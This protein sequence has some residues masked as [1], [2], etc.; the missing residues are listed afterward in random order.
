MSKKKEITDYSVYKRLL[1]YVAPHKTSIIVAIVLASVVS[2]ATGAIAWIVK[3]VMDQLF[4]QK[5]WHMLNIL[6]FA[7][8]LIFLIKGLGRFYQ[9]YLMRRL[10]ETII[11]Q[12]R[13]ELYD[14]LLDMSLGY[15]QRIHSAVLMSRITNDVNLLADISSRVIAD[16]FRQVFTLVVLLGV[17]FY[18]N[19]R[20]ALIYCVVTPLVVVPITIIGK[21]LRRISKENQKKIAH[22]N[23][24]LMETFVGTKIVK[25]FTMEGYRKERFSGENHKLYK[26]N[27]RGIVAYELLSPMMESMG[28]VGMGLVIYFGGREVIMGHTSPG[29]FFS[30][31]AALGML[32]APLRKLSKMHGVVQKSLA[33][34]ERV[35]EVLDEKNEIVDRKEAIPLERLEDSIVFN[36]VTFSYDGESD[37]LK[38]IN[39]STRLGESIALVGLS[40]GGKST[41]VDLIARFYE[42]NQGTITL[43]QV[44]IRDYQVKSLRESIAIVTQEAVLF[45]DTIM[46]NIAYGRENPDRQEVIK[47]ARM[48][49]A[50]D[51]INALPDGYETMIQERGTNF[52]GGQRKRI[53]LARAFYKNADILI[54]DEASSELDSESEELVKQALEKLLE[55][56]TAFIV[57]HRLSTIMH[58]DQILV[59]EKG[60]ITERGT[61]QELLE[62]RGVYR[63][64]CSL[65]FID[66]ESDSLKKP[67]EPE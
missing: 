59:I 21:K 10:G 50:H 36:N 16:F 61:H 64:L 15:Y 29:T 2:V 56:K 67:A 53:T 3:P 34:A 45:N 11:T 27:M 46:N 43:D 25:A 63:K 6:P 51:F 42:V 22:L 9:S 39:L 40:G 8:V 20:L 33:A 28:A 41:L 17:V 31:L 57:A 24:I 54:L 49:Y 65:Q 35:F 44:D 37:V 7:L 32:Y 18:H 19:W 4:V 60:R 52:S 47:A 12:L 5:D 38:D 26:I 55:G 1:P 13:D 48:A 66:V 23:T 62:Q 14:H 58:C 30:F